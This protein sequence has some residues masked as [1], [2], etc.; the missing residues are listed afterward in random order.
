VEPGQYIENELSGRGYGW[1]NVAREIGDRL[2]G[3]DALRNTGAFV[4]VTQAASGS[5]WL[6]PPNTRTATG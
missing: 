2:G 1:L 5:H 6:Q 4:D 3:V